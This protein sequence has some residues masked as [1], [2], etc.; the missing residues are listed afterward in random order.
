[1]LETILRHG[2]GAFYLYF[3]IERLVMSHSKALKHLV[4]D[5]VLSGLGDL[6]PTSASSTKT[7]KVCL[8]GVIL[9]FG[10]MDFLSKQ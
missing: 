3:R 9:L 6:A 7:W 1:M 10:M 4:P 2:R 8:Y 5:G